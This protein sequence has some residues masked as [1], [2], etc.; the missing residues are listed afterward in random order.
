MMIPTIFLRRALHSRSEI[1]APLNEFRTRVN[2][3]LTS[4]P[5]RAEQAL[6]DSVATRLIPEVGSTPRRRDRNEVESRA[7][8]RRDRWLALSVGWHRKAFHMFFRAEPTVLNLLLCAFPTH[9]QNSSSN[10]DNV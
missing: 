1:E 6:P 9:R 3:V 8:R 4:E 2:A 5:K 10:A 7:Y